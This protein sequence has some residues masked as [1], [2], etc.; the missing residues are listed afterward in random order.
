MARCFGSGKKSRCH[1]GIHR[2][3][4]PGGFQK[5]ISGGFGM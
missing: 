3:I 4:E 5:G 1:L 2:V